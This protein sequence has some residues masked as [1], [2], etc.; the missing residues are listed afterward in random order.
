MDM[1]MKL[2]AAYG[3]NMNLEQ[4]SFRCPAARRLGPALL[5]GHRL[6]FRG[7]CGSA[8]ATVEPCADGKVPVLL[9]AI[10]PGDEAA[11]DRYEGY[12]RLYRKELL[13]VRVKSRYVRAMAYIMN[14]GRPP[15]RPGNFYY[16]VI[17]EGYRDAGFDESILND[18]VLF[19]NGGSM[20]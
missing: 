7:E 16:G 14:G 11:L 8:V 6:V 15:R 12:P 1:R 10:G 5:E 4:M 2:Y 13:D 17:Q 9:W 3:S 19:S 18:A 20:E